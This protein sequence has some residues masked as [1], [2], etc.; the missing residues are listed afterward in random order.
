[1]PNKVRENSNEVSK[2]SAAKP[3]TGDRRKEARMRQA[4]VR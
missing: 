4:E 3:A 2:L 1:M